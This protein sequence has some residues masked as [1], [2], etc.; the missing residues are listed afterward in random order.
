MPCVCH[1]L[2]VRGEKG[3]WGSKKGYSTPKQSWKRRAT[4][5]A[6]SERRRFGKSANDDDGSDDDDDDGEDEEEEEEDDD[7]NDDNHDFQKES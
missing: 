5:E 7:D 6:C 4:C 1:D 2:R 3:F